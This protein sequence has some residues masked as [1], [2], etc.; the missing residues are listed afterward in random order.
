[1][2]AHTPERRRLKALGR[3]RRV[4]RDRREELADLAPG[5][6]GDDA[7]AAAGSQH[8][9]DLGR[10]A[11]WSGSE[12]AAEG[13]QTTTSK[14]LLVKR[15][16]LGVALDPLHLDPGRGRVS[17]RV[18]E[19]LRGDVE[20][21]VTPPLTARRDRALPRPRRRREP[22]R[23]RGAHP[24]DGCSPTSLIRW[25]IASKSP[26]DQVAR[27]RSCASVARNRPSADPIPAAGTNIGRQLLLQLQHRGE[28]VAVSLDPLERPAGPRSAPSPGRRRRRA[29]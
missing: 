29:R 23:P 3:R 1:M 10:G 25:A 14:R 28:E 15:Q 5:R 12:H 19:Q 6:P 21:G 2:V 24:R 26:A 18:L 9:G 27:A 17:A 7:E 4:L 11:L 16:V 13:R 20:A 22:A 8:P